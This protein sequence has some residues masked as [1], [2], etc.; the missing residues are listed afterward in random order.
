MEWVT[1]ESIYDESWRRLLEY[2]NLDIALD[3][4]NNIHG[5][6]ADKKEA[7][8]YE[9]QAQQARVSLLQ[10]NEYFDAAQASS[11]FTKPNHLYYGAVSLSSA[12]MLIRGDGSKSLDFLRQNS[13]NKHH[14]LD[15]TFNLN[16]KTASK[17][18]KLLEQCFVKILPNGHFKNWYE[19]LKP[20]YPTHGII[21]K[22]G[23]TS[24]DEIG[25]IKAPL[26]AKLTNL[27][28]STLDLTKRLPDLYDELNRFGVKVS[29]ARG[30]HS[31][32]IIDKENKIRK[33]E[34]TFHSSPDP[35]TLNTLCGLFKYDDQAQLEKTVLNNG[36]SARLTFTSEE[37]CM[38]RSWPNDR[39]TLNHKNY[40][41]TSS[42]TSAPEVVDLFIISYALSMLSR[43]Y[44]DIWVNFIESHCKAAKIV[45][46]IC[47]VL[48][49]KLP[50][51]MLS[52]IQHSHVVLSN[53]RPLWH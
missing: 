12:C 48:L 42:S 43:Y 21:K 7:K 1:C 6:P 8:N 14:G 47:R 25:S 13:G 17:G 28:H 29:A 31:I 9:K 40:F 49:L 22:L 24:M 20:A 26:F 16:A 30:E 2:A 53:H 41:Y 36:H 5:E 19:T 37:N 50:M 39:S 35:E 15:L 44:P 18:I 33:H 51:L 10:A 4:I 45:E 52:E 27:K 32:D 46:N 11:M 34:F 38:L 3:R 23:G